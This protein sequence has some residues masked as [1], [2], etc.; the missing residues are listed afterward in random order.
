MLSATPIQLFGALLALVGVVVVG[1]V[2]HELLHALALTVA[3]VPCRIELFPDRQSGE[4]LR[5]GVPGTW[6]SVTPTGVPGE[7]SPWTLRVS[8]MMPLCLA[9][10]FGLALVGVV[11]NPFAV[12]SLVLQVAAIAWL[13]CALPSPQDFSLLWYPEQTLAEHARE[14]ETAT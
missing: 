7:L 11:P 3:G 2:T 1:T 12:D 6:A 8:A 4:S 9:I 14:S 5:A 13:G 10:P